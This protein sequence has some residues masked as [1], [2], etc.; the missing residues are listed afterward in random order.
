MAKISW[1]HLI[2]ALADISAEVGL[3]GEATSLIIGWPS[4][5]EALAAVICVELYGH[6]EAHGV[7]C[8]D[9]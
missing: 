1:S 6:D 8:A 7:D 2:C 9:L 3:C 4:C 5:R